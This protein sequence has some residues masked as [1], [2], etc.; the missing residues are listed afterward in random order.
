MAQRLG[1]S[2]MGQMSF[3]FSNPI[4]YG[5]LQHT[6][7]VYKLNRKIGPVVRSVAAERDVVRQV[8]RVA[9]ML[10]NGKRMDTTI[11]ELFSDSTL[12]TL[13]LLGASK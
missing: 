5:D 9:V 8:T 4:E 7:W 10:H 6:V 1:K 3:D 2:R 12:A 13:V 11:D